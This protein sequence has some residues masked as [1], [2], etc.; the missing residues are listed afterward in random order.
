MG[1]W[2]L[3]AVDAVPGDADVVDSVAVNTYLIL[4]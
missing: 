4:V 3:V 1:S 2:R